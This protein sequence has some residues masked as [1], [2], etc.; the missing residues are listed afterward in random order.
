M[1]KSSLAWFAVLFGLLSIGTASAATGGQAV[2]PLAAGTCTGTACNGVPNDT[3]NAWFFKPATGA[4]MAQET[5]GNLA[6]IVTNTTGAASALNQTKVQSAPGTPQTTAET[7]QGNAG[8][9][10]VPVSPA[11]SSAPTSA[12]ALTASALLESNHVLK[13][14]AGNLYGLSIT[15][16]ATAGYLLVFDAT[17]PPADGA[18]LPKLCYPVAANQWTT[19]IGGTGIPMAFVSG[20][21]VVFSTTGCFSKTASATAFFSAQV[22]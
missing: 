20:I 3:N 5:G 14:A 12:I 17:T 13:A 7:I 6:A 1:R 16:G 9:I 11:P 19:T 15:T 2:V 8:G 18:V 10:P 22:Q 4:N 21:T